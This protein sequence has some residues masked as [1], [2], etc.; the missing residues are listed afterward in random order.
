MLH[1]PHQPN[2]STLPHRRGYHRTAFTLIELLVVIG[3]LVILVAILVPVISKMRIAAYTAN[4]R[5]EIKQIASG[6]DQY[7]LDFKAYPGPFPEASLQSPNQGKLYPNATTVQI[8]CTSTEN[9][10]F[11]LLGG[12]GESS[13]TG[14]ASY[15]QAAVGQGQMSFNPVAQFAVRYHTYGNANL[16][17]PQ[18][19]AT[20]PFSN[21]SSPG[22]PPLYSSSPLAFADRFPPP[23]TLPMP[24]L[25]LRAHNGANGVTSSDMGNT[26]GGVTVTQVQYDDG[27]CLPYGFDTTNFPTDPATGTQDFMASA[28]AGTSAADAYF[29]QSS[30]LLARQ[31]NRYILISA[32]PDGIFGTLDDIFNP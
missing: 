10:I 31:P 19:W 11:G 7:F 28:T 9:L 12:A 15:L 27:Q 24:I 29:G 2:A 26:I 30:G 6:I 22:N 5:N 1:P 21:G 20:P 8:M 18:P 32:G 4:T 17:M 16:L 23:N 13:G 3:I 25:Y 14:P